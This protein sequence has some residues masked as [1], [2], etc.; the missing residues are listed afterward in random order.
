VGLEKA[1]ADVLLLLDS[2]SASG[3]IN[4]AKPKD[5]VPEGGKTEG[6]HSQL[7]SLFLVQL[8]EY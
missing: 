3:S 7:R 8:E 4:F 5:V 2:C 6:K 1:D